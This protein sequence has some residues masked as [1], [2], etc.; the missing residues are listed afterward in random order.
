MHAPIH[1]EMQKIQHRKN[2]ESAFVCSGVF[3]LIHPL[4]KSNILWILTKPATE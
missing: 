4:K 1:T 2:C 3:N